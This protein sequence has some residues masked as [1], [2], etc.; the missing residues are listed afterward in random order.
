MN[1]LSQGAGAGVVVKSFHSLHICKGHDD[2]NEANSSMKSTKDRDRERVYLVAVAAE[3]KNYSQNLCIRESA[4]LRTILP[5]RRIQFELRRDPGEVEIDAVD[6]AGV[7]HAPAQ[8]E[9]LSQAVV[10]GGALWVR[11]TGMS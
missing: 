4:R 5:S 1:G 3:R 11:R 8:H 7:A 10:L 9:Q 6:H 2:R